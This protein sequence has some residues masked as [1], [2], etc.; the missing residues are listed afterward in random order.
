MRAGVPV[1]LLLA[2]PNAGICTRRWRK[3]ET[4]V[5]VSGELTRH[6]M[7]ELNR[8]G[9]HRPP[10]TPAA[11]PELSG[12]LRRHPEA[13]RRPGSSPIARLQPVHAE[14][15]GEKEDFL[16]WVKTS[17]YKEGNDY[18]VTTAAGGCSCSRP[19]TSRFPSAGPEYATEMDPRA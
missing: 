11:L 12:R 9:R 17:T 4:A 3:T 1:G 13:R 8:L 19:P 7:R 5:R 18:S 14:A 16:N 2:K 15:E 6:F 10:S